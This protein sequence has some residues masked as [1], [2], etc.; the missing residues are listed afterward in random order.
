MPRSR[1]DEVGV[2]RDLWRHSS[3]RLGM[4]APAV[5]V[6]AEA[7]VPVEVAASVGVPTGVQPGV[8]AEVGAFALS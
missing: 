6:G 3:I 2:L 1:V 5:L 8:E 4:A 7:G